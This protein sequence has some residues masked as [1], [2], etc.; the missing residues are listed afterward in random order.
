MN[1]YELDAQFNHPAAPAGWTPAAHALT[2]SAVPSSLS[3]FAG[4]ED[5]AFVDSGGHRHLWVRFHAPALTDQV[6]AR[7]MVVTI[8]AQVP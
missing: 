5:A 7:A 3:R 2:A 6:G 1:R 8:A 4:D